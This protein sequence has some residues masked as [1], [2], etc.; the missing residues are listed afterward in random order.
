MP[1][2]LLACSLLNLHQAATTDVGQLPNPKPGLGLRALN[3]SSRKKIPKPQKEE[4]HVKDF[5]GECFEKLL[6]PNSKIPCPTLLA[7]GQREHSRFRD[8]LPQRLCL[9]P[10]PRAVEYCSRAGYL[11]Q[12]KERLHEDHI[13]LGFELMLP[14][15][16]HQI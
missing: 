4:C 10:G 7:K 6:Y 1:H 8:A 2:S 14:Q 13:R 11:E 16:E 3:P 9:R 15:F 12:N 5:V